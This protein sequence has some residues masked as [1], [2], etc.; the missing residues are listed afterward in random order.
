MRLLWLGAA[1]RAASVLAQGISSCP[2][3]IASNVQ[4][5]SS[6]IT[7]DLTLAGNPCNAYGDDIKDLKL[8]VEYQ[9]GSRLHVK[10]YDAEERVYQIPDDILSMPKPGDSSGP[11]DLEF[12]LEENPF[13]F[14]VRRTSNNQVLFNTSGQ[15]LVF[16][17]QYLRLRTSLPNN[18]NIYGFGE[19]ADPLRHDPQ[20]Y[21]HV[22]WNSGEAFMPPNAN[23][24]GSYPIYYDHRGGDGTHAVYLHNSNGKRINL[25]NDSEEFLEYNTLGG[26]FDFYFLSGPSPKDASAQLAGVIGFPTLMP[27]WGFGFHQC[28]YGY[29]DTLE[30]AAVVANYSAANIPL[31]TIWNDIDYMDYRSTF[32][33]DPLRFPLSKMREFVNY[34]H[35]HNQH[36]IVMVDPAVASRDYPPFHD[37]VEKNA[38][39]KE[40]NGTLYTGVVWPGPTNFPDWLAPHTQDFWDEQFGN[41]FNANS[42]VDIDGLWIDM[43]EASN[44]CDYPCPDP[45]KYSIEGRDPPRPPPARMSSPYDI[46]GFPA[47]FQPKCVATVTFNV[48]ALVPGG[49]DLLLFGDTVSIGNNTPFYAP[50]MQGSNGSWSLTA[51]FPANSKVTYSYPL[52][53]HEGLYIFEAQNRTLHTQDC[54]SVSSVSDDWSVPNTSAVAV[55]DVF[56][57]P[58]QT[59]TSKFDFNSSDPAGSMKGLPGRDLIS[60]PYNIGTYDGPLS[61]QTLPTN[62]HHANGLAEYDVHNLYSSMMGRRS[63]NSMIKRRPGKRPLMYG[64]KTSYLPDTPR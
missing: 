54:G 27:Y 35:H 60:P 47:D 44:F 51:Q 3:Y 10:I 7:A 18:P 4:D 45:K 14:S 59:S 8:L 20:N 21:T 2:G 58:V 46:P 42:G 24:Y 17:S 64:S 40:D 6:S 34:L 25:G 30:T 52:Y 48:G 57:S 11:R 38:F 26:V 12:A 1:L 32:S 41:F 49:N 62:L 55:P 15:A 19:N 39:M 22:D 50:N 13:S 63:R 16:E 5:S 9:T 31:E 43:N 37:G 56:Y 53:T 61:S 29:Q 33:L 28:K 36:Y 23:L